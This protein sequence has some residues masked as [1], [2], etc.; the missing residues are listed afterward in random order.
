LSITFFG[1][2]ADAAIAGSWHGAFTYYFCKEMSACKNTLSR[3]KVL[4]KV[5]AGLKKGHY[6]Q[7]PQLETEATQR[8]LAVSSEMA[9][10]AGR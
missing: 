3:A 4:A 1:L 5:R 2:P 10:A 6:S 8:Q 7:T 9:K